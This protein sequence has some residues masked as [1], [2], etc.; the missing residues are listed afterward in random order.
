MTHVTFVVE[1]EEKV[2]SALLGSQ[3]GSENLTNEDKYTGEKH[4]HL[5][6]RSFT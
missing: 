5:F 4:T 1:G 6:N 3:A 2:S